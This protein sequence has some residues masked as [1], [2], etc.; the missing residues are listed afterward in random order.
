MCVTL[1]E[2]SWME[3]SAAGNEAVFLVTLSL[4]TSFLTWQPGAIPLNLKLLSINDFRPG[5][6]SRH[7]H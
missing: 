3:P 4:G 5:F 7:F 1:P 6:H 2:K